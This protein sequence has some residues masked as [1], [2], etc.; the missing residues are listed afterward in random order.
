LDFVGGSQSLLLSR[1]KLAGQAIDAE[2]RRRELVAHPRERIL[3][4][5]IGALGALRGNPFVAGDPLEV[6]V[7]G[8]GTGRAGQRNGERQARSE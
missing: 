7:S 3:Q 2:L 1:R 5:G 8:R 4:L 6:K